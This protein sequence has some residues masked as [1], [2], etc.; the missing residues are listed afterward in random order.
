M[1]NLHFDRINALFEPAEFS[2]FPPQRLI[3]LKVEEWYKWHD[4]DSDIRDLLLAQP[5]LQKLHLVSETKA[6]PVFPKPRLREPASSERLPPLRE[7][8]LDGYHWDYPPWAAVNF[9]DWS[10]IIH[11][12]LRN[13]QVDNFLLTVPPQHLSRLQ[14]FITDSRGSVGHRVSIDR[15]LCNVVAQNSCLEELRMKYVVKKS[16]LVSM[17]ARNGS[18]LRI[19]DLRCC[20]RP[21]KS[22]WLPLSKGE[23]VD[24]NSGCPQL[25]ELEVDIA[26]PLIPRR[27]SGGAESGSE[28]RETPASSVSLPRSTSAARDL[29]DS[30]PEEQLSCFASS[31]Q[32]KPI[33]P[34]LRFPQTPTTEN[35][36]QYRPLRGTGALQLYA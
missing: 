6:P 15:L 10:N 22:S 32:T 34:T 7:L 21:R 8:V 23:L 18:V 24:L 20:N 2:G 14:T 30:R 25:I 13:T 36:H 31:P 19:L 29:S 16:T 11:L 1:V 35:L 28:I 17:V 9:W 5:N 26:W 3:T 27:L 12:E 4:W 33:T